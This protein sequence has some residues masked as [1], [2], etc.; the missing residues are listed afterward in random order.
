MAELKTG[1]KAE[2]MEK[3]CLLACSQWPNYLSWRSNPESQEHIKQG[4]Y[5]VSHITSLSHL[6]YTAQSQLCRGGPPTSARN[7]DNAPQTSPPLANLMEAISQW[8]FSLPSYIWV[9]VKLLKTMTVLYD[10]L[11]PR[12]CISI[13]FLS[14]YLVLGAGHVAQW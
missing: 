3:C 9:Y 2:A 1:T 5:Q 7:P 13:L 6:H 8:R 10:Y 4:L 11:F 14:K 12:S